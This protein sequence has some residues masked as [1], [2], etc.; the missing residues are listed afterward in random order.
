MMSGQLHYSAFANLDRDHMYFEG[1]K[2]GCIFLKT[3]IHRLE[4]LRSE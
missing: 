2:A 4:G 3:P 1:P